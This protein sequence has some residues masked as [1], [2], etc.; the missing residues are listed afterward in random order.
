MRGSTVPTVNTY[1]AATP[2]AATAESI[3][4]SLRAGGGSTPRCATTI[5]SRSKPSLTSSS[6]VNAETEITRSALAP[7]QLQPAPVEGDAAPR[8]HLRHA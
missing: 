7:R 1:G 6:R 4:S 3:S 2:V 8:A 5:E